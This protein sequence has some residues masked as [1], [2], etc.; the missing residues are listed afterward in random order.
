MKPRVLIGG[1]VRQTPA[2][3]TEHLESL[4]RLST[5]GLN[6]HYAF[7]DDNVE[8]GSR[9]LL[10]TFA[11][12]CENVRIL[13][14]TPDDAYHCDETT[15]HWREDLIWKV[16]R[17]KNELLSIARSEDYDFIFLVDSDLYLHPETLSH[18]VSLRKDIVSEVFWTKWRPELIALP[19]VWAM[20]QYQLY[21][22]PRGAVLGEEETSGRTMAF[23]QMLSRPGTYRVGG[24]GACTLISRRALSAG[25][26]FSEIYNLGFSGED[27]H[28][29]IRAVALGLELY[30]D[31]HYPPF[32]I[33]RSSELTALR[34]YKATVLSKDPGGEIMT[35]I[36]GGY[37]RV[38]N[39]VRSQITLAMLVRNEADRYLP[40]V[41]R[42]AAQYVDQAVI[43]DDAST[44]NT[45]EVCRQALQGIPAFIHVGDTPGFANEVNLRRR[46][47]ELAIAHEAEW[48]LCLDADEMFEDRAVTMIKELVQRADVDVWGFRLFD[49]WDKEHYRADRLW[50]AHQRYIPFLV[51]YQPHFPYQW[52]ESPLHCG[53]FPENITLL[54]A[55]AC[56]LRLK[57]FGWATEADR[58]QKYE[59]YMEADPD[60]KYGV[61][62]Q[63][64]SILD[65]APNLIRW[66]ERNVKS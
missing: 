65:P 26:S 12:R 5:H 28:F 57:H 3:L 25:V 53:R 40:A 4:E 29:C 34:D 21:E 63:Y 35:F 49:F 24:L 9:E 41:L 6:V 16:A 43:L 10:A 11:R 52:R 51:R 30:A 60:G 48:I 55:L 17:F 19:Q 7:V 32:H 36:H 47:W 42:H 14:G 39:T 44:D 45:V 22:A 27:R 56:D 1:P 8:A 2:I 61:L 37:K 64:R 50:N 62:D 33:Y 66:Q 15:H 31:T 13:T 59:R 18:L 38:V 46:L 20:D 23:L 58:R 54:P